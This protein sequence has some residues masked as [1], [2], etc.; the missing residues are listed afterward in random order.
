M[1]SRAGQI[2]RGGGG[3]S[4][5]TLAAVLSSAL[6]AA[7]V[8]ALTVGAGPADAVPVAM[9]D[10]G[11]SGNV[12]DCKDDDDHQH[13]G[14][15]FG[16]WPHWAPKPGYRSGDDDCEPAPPP[17]PPPPPVEPP[18]PQIPSP[19][20]PAPAAE[21]AAQVVVV[22]QKATIIDGN[23]DCGDVATEPAD[24]MAPGVSVER[25]SDAQS[26]D[27]CKPVPYT[28]S[29][30]DNHVQFLKSGSP[31][32]Q[33]I[34]T[35]DWPTELEP[36]AKSKTWVDFELVP[37]YEV[38]LGNCPAA[39]YS[40]GALVGLTSIE[41]QT[42]QSLAALGIGDQDGLPR[43]PVIAA[44]GTVLD[45]GTTE[46]N[47]ITQY[48]CVGSRSGRFVPSTPDSEPYYIVTEQLY[49]LGDVVWRG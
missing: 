41:T 48:A 9:H 23:L 35:V 1:T 22:P 49:L 19:P 4:R 11:T 7:S 42:P 3:T 18:P 30:Y 14:D 25:L 47:G 38:L 43:A 33:F 13:D 12:G 6:M 32:A 45:A 40:G 31:Y 34:V 37:G 26:A 46:D 10:S 44:D 27:P 5:R 36:P 16:N 2:R 28:L 39:L 24:D 29:T 15:G 8:V 21:P 20:P 17:P